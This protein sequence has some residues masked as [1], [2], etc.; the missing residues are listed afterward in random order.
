[1]TLK[2]DNS[3]LWHQVFVFVAC[4]RV[5]LRGNC[6]FYCISGIKSDCFR[7]STLPK[8]LWD[9]C[10]LNRKREHVVEPVGLC[11]LFVYIKKTAAFVYM[12]RTF[13]CHFHRNETEE[14]LINVPIQFFNFRSGFES[15]QQLNIVLK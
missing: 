12:T 6:Q 3:S 9:H 15:L 7:I 1:M 8:K 4:S 13:S 11:Q 5:V 10:F 2:I 14:E